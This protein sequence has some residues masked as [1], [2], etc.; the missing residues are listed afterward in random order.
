MIAKPH[1]TVVVL[2]YG[3]QY[4]RLITRR[5]RE[6]GIFSI[7]LNGRTAQT[8]VAKVFE[9][10]PKAI[11]LS[12]GPSS[13]YENN[14]PKLSPEFFDRQAK[15]K[16][17]VLGI[18]YGLQ[19]LAQALGGEVR[20]S[21]FREY[22]R[23]VVDVEDNSSFFPLAIKKSL[24]VWMSHGDSLVK[25]PNGFKTIAKSHTGA[26]AAVEDTSRNLYG[27]QFHPEVSH[28][29]YGSE[30]LKHFFLEVA[31]IKPDWSMK[32]VLEEQIEKIRAMV[33]E[34]EHVL[35]GLSGGV[36][37][38]VAA[39]LVHRAIGDRLHCVF[40]DHG[41]LRYEER[42]RVMKMFK[43]DLHLPVNCVE[44]GSKFLAKLKG[45][46]DPEEKRKIIGTEF[47]LSFEAFAQNMKMET[48]S[49]PKYLVQG[50]LYPDV[51]ESSVGHATATT[52]KTHH[53]VGGLPKN[54]RFQ[55]IEPLRDL[56]KD[57]VRTLG[58]NLNIQD[59]F[60]MRHPFPGPGLAVRIIGEITPERLEILRKADEIYISS[61]REYGL[62]DQI[63][64]AFAVFLP[65][66]SVGVQGD[67][68]THD[69]VIALRAVTSTDG[70]TADWYPFEHQFLAKV[71]NRICNEVKGVNRVVYD[72]S[73]K[74]PATIE[75]E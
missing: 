11:I 27:L 7:I 29:E 59:S 71:S 55:L 58:R 10:N 31:Q 63:W 70:M 25:L 45:V 35:C 13:V 34:N 33:G 8:D 67:G 73:S 39:V 65:I 57:E 75:W 19:L 61:L 64:Q 32:S 16:T 30:L 26:I 20:G 36:D 74:P 28:T 38:T 14:A 60:L 62:Y 56:F 4:T 2:D 12:G 24:N 72:I 22:G 51:I 41:L 68:R 52:I 18:C 50:T 21:V 42:E 40:V 43:D 48:G 46:Q 37:S 54:L 3:S 6:M 23:N 47:I 44:D 1:Q 53:N 9:S 15:T 66:K 49:L 5:I 17:P 69:H